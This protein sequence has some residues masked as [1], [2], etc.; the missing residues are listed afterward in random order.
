VEE[1]KGGGGKGGGRG[2]MSFTDPVCGSVNRI[3]K[4]VETEEQE[5]RRM[6]TRQSQISCLIY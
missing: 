4:R 1:E 2:G 6:E 5:T 3:G